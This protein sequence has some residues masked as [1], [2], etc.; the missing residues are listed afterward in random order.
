[1]LKE[2][3]ENI[4][5]TAKLYGASWLITCLVIK[6]ICWCFGFSFSWKV[7][8]GIWLCLIL[9]ESVLKGGKGKN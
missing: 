2:M 5:Y 1:M 6:L 3:L 8:T 7:A 4:A 9:A